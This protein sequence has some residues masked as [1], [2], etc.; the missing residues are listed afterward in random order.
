M[1]V[2]DQGAP[3]QHSI[4]AGVQ[5]GTS[6]GWTRLRAGHGAMGPRVDEW[7]WGQVRASSGA[8]GWGRGGGPGAACA[9]TERASPMWRV[10]L[11][12]RHSSG[13]WRWRA[14]A[15]RWRRGWP[16]PRARWGG[17]RMRTAS[18][19]AGMG[20]SRWR[21]WRTPACAYPGHRRSAATANQ[22]DLG[23]GRRVDPVDGAGRAARAQRLRV[24][25]P[26]AT[27]ANLAQVTLAAPPPSR[28]TALSSPTSPGTPEAPK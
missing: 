12:R 19:P 23:P 25:D 5:Q 9:P 27:R 24:G 11:R 2:W 17:T 3:Q 1:W 16:R 18:G 10:R 7:A 20:T 13:G 14:H 26:R 21:C 8:G 6:D 22:G 15:G 4:R 28:G